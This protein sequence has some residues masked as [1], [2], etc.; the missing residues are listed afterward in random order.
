[1]NVPLLDLKAQFA[2][3]REQILDVIT[4]VCDSQRF[5]LGPE[6]E[7]LEHELAEALG[8]KHA[9]AVSSG[10]DALLVALMA[11][12]IG[13]GDEVI[14]TPYTFFATG[15]TVARTGARPTFVDIEPDTYNISPAAIEAFIARDC[16]TRDG[17]L[18]NRATGGRVRALMPV[19]LYGQVANMTRIME[20]AQRHRLRVIEDAAQA[21]GAEDE[22]GRRACSECPE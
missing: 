4:R 19:H 10:T 7:A 5:I 21:I 2:P 13:A 8:V 9:L 3:L 6:V 18:I 15:G 11:L 16:E 14:T 20:I 12:E 1:V 17:A 22:R